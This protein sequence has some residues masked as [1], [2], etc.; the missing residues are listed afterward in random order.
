MSSL[1]LFALLAVAALAA[2]CAQNNA[3]PT[4]AT[5]TGTSPTPA[6]TTGTPP[7]SPTSNGLTSITVG[8][9]AAYPPFEDTQ[10]DGK[11]V[12]FDIDVMTEI[13]NRS[14]F[15]P[16]FQNAQFQ[17]IIP[18]IQSG[19]FDAG[20][21]AFT[22]TDE[23]KQQVSFS[24]SYYDNELMVA[25][26]AANTDIAKPTD[27]EGKKVCTQTG[28]TSED[29]LRANVNATNDTL[30]LL[31]AFPPCADA[32][33]RG[34]VQAMMIDRAVVRDLIAKSNGEMKQAF[35]IPTDE[36]FGIAVAKTNAALLTRLN[37]A[38]VAMKQDGTLDRLKDK[39][40]V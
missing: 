15:T 25:V 18:S 8:T 23:R 39:W 6:T 21:S 1:K 10:T 32:L 11:I 37:T 19:Q 27:L 9:E 13:G 7:T 34:D 24:V 20:I 28:T 36:Q 35:V 17:A 16:H 12:G 33:K 30:T 29:W 14:G 3:N 5:T 22:I 26:L 2:G 40:S 31:D 4:P 38:L